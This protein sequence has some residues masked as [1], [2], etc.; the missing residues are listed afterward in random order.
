MRFRSLRLVAIAAAAGLACDSTLIGTG[1]MANAYV[2]TQSTSF[3]PVQVT[4]QVGQTVLWAFGSGN[5]NVLFDE[6]PGA[7]ADCPQVVSAGTCTRQFLTAGS[8][9]FFCGPHY[10]VGMVGTVVVNP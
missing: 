1:Q 2:T 3:A 10:S 8:F 7:P 9:G 5:H 6:I 4:I